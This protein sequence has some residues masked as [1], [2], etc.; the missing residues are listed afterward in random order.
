MSS[1]NLP[2]LSLSIN[3]LIP[4][5]IQGSIKMKWECC[6]GINP[7]PPPRGDVKTSADFRGRWVWVLL[8][9]IGVKK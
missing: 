7:S 3:L 6:G 9:G 4:T 2:S 1:V 8:E 5:H